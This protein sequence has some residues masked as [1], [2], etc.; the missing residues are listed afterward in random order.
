[1][2]NVHHLI[3]HESDIINSLHENIG[4]TFQN[5]KTDEKMWKDACKQ[6]HSY[7]SPMDSFIDRMYASSNIKDD[8]LLEFV[9]TFLEI[10]PMFFRS[11]YIKEDML[12][13]LKRTKLNKKQE[14]R[15]LSI[16]VD[17]AE[18][19]G[20]RE[21]KRYCRLAKNIATESLITNLKGIIRFGRTSS[22]SR[23]KLMLQYIN[24]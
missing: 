14:E 4:L 17:A 9:I 5:R 22:K 2:T 16:L 18:N 21:F 6:F 1:M 19:R 8:E 20:S 3:I 13:K 12:I 23:A 24:T 10:D 15:V 11:G 7:I